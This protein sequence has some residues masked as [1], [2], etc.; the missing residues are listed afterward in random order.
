MARTPAAAEPA[1]A[2]ARR[3]LGELLGTLLLVA[4]VVGSGIAARRLS[5][6]DTG[7]ELL[8]NAVA[9]GAA[10]VA[11]ILTVGPVSGAHLNPVV[12]AVDFASG[13]LTR[14]A[15]GVYVPAQVLGGIAGA[16]LANAMFAL[17]P[18]SIAQ[19]QLE[20]RLGDGEVGVAGLALGRLDPE[21]LAVEGDRLVDVGDVEGQLDS[22]HD[23]TPHE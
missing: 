21:E 23:L 18:V 7:L 13:G 10:L 5:P 17:A 14:R 4:A 1:P 6:N 12:S 19:H 2:L 9:T 11:I 3:A 20:R 16:V 15:L 22:R 8:E